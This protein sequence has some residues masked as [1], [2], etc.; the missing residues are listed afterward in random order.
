[1]TM[2]RAWCYQGG[3]KSPALQPWKLLIEGWTLLEPAV[4][5]V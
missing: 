2:L 1:M 3:F 4:E 5:S